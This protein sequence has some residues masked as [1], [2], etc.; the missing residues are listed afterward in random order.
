MRKRDRAK[1][2]YKLLLYRVDNCLGMLKIK[3]YKTYEY[4]MNILNAKN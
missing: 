3:E 1:I 2:I 4:S